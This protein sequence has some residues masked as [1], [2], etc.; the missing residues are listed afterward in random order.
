MRLPRK[1]AQGLIR[2]YQL[3]LSGLIGRQ[4]RHL[5]TCSDYTMEAIGRHGL[6]AGGWMGVARICRCGPFGTSGLDFV[7]EEIP[8]GACWYRPWRYGLWRGTR[9]TRAGTSARVTGPS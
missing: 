6:W 7:C 8:A 5:P 1:G 9:A 3:S 4:C 2:A